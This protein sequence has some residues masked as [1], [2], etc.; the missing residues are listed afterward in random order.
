M[1]EVLRIL[2]GAGAV[3]L[4]CAGAG[5]ALW[6]WKPPAQS[7][8]FATGA[9][10]LSLA[11]FALLATGLYGTAA[12]SVVLAAAIAAGRWGKPSF[13][14]APWWAVAAGAV[15]LAL[16]AV[17]ALAPEIQPDAAG[18]H[19]GLPAQWLREGGFSGTI[20]FFEMLPLGVETLFGAAMAL[21]GVSAAKVLHF[22]FLALTAPLTLHVSRRLGLSDQ[23]GWAA[24]LL[25][26]V[27][28]V[29]GISG[30]SAYTDAAL[31]FAHL[32]LFAVLLEWKDS[33]CAMI[34]AHAGLMAGLC[35]SIKVTGA[36]PA[37]AVALYLLWRKRAAD[38]AAFAAGASAVALPWVVKAWWLT[39]N[40]LAPLGNAWIDNDA[41][42]AA[43]EQALGSYLRSYG[44][45]SWMDIPR[46]LLLDGGP[47]QGLLGPVFVLAILSIVAIRKPAGRWLMAAAAVA[48]VPWAM[49]IGARFLMPAMPLVWLA[50]VSVMPARVLPA[51]V[52]FHGA[53]SLPVAMDRYAGASAW[54]LKG[55]PWAA[56]LR[57]EPE[58]RYLS[59]NYLEFRAA[60]MVAE[61]VKAGEQI[62]DLMGLPTLYTKTPA[63][64][65]LPTAVFDQ[66]TSTL[67]AAAAP[68]SERLYEARFPA[69]GRFMRGVKVRLAEPSRI[70]WPLS[71]MRF[72]RQGGRVRVPRTWFVR[73]WPVPQDAALA[74]DGNLASRWQTYGQAGE[75]SFVE[76]LFDR[77]IPFDTISV[78]S[79]MLARGG[80]AIE[81]YGLRM[82][83][84]WVRLD[85]V[86]AARALPPIPLRGEAMS[87]LKSRG[88]RWIVA[89]VG[90]IGHG[91]VGRS[92]MTY[93][94]AWRVE[95]VKQ[96]DGVWLF[97]L[98]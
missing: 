62:V 58:E 95:R 85:A 37:V 65:P 43:T 88:I 29:V 38:T 23:A 6:R 3:A 84:Q 4:A 45:A 97:R 48:A 71:E 13:G 57:I 93:P 51:I 76:V 41:F 91:P 66:M 53:L 33:P 11:M 31:V 30:T 47:L 60:R 54:R 55:W 69:P 7:I 68:V 10:A 22:V 21:G 5:R 89:P 40:P 34:A 18:Y 74:V 16:Y 59:E 73:A 52:L 77:P 28:P 98:R 36:I 83:R 49:N 92:L 63:H 20:G 50:A 67:A 78:I 96:I 19:L 17:H 8:A 35:Y 94:N 75:G 14:P 27:T 46:A 25:Y 81:V 44:I 15:F 2:G 70:G 64:G 72:E 32:A 39:G 42:N 1:F 87:F 82:D 56:A 9:A 26:G 79:P 86:G 90:E 12:I 24:A 61:Y 80:P